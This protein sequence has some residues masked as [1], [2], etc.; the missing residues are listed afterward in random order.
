MSAHK[1]QV[2][3][4]KMGKVCAIK[5]HVAMQ[6]LARYMFKSMEESLDRTAVH[7]YNYVYKVLIMNYLYSPVKSD[8]SEI[9]HNGG[10]NGL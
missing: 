4:D 10:K 2:V 7:W 6:I 9:K 1:H 3:T 5:G 8:M